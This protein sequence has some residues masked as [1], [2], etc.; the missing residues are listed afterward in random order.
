MQQLIVESGVNSKHYSWH[1]AKM[2]KPLISQSFGFTL[3][4]TG[5]GLKHSGRSLKFT[6]LWLLALVNIFILQTWRFLAKNQT[7]WHYTL[8]SLPQN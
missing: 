3:V 5:L 1:S 4:T 8:K 7:P 6:V 2:L